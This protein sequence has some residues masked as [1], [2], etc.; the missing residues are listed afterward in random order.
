MGA[1][2]GGTG[3]SVSIEPPTGPYLYGTVVTATA[4]ADTGYAFVE[5]S[6][7]G[8]PVS[9]GAVYTFTVTSDHALSAAFAPLSYNIG[10]VGGGAGG[11]VSIEPPTGP[12]AYGAAITVT[13][14]ADPGYAFA[15]WSEGGTPISTSALYTFIVAGDHALSASFTQLSYSVSTATAGA[16]SG[17]VSLDPPGGI[18]TYGAVVTATATAGAGSAFAD[19][20]G[21]CSGSG[22]CVLTVDGDKSITATFATAVDP[23]PHVAIAATAG[24]TQAIVGETIIT[25]TYQVTNTGAVPVAASVRDSRHGAVALAIPPG[26]VPQPAISLPGVPQTILPWA[27]M[28]DGPTAARTLG[29]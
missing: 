10:V 13:A 29:M 11:S 6:D 4:T 15:G 18:Y 1:V 7:G 17:L 14:T 27:F 21:D 5:W 12:Y 9:P 16:G 2:T 26:G 24:V 22:A 20:S 3:G 8:V 19:W 28:N 23:L 25:Y